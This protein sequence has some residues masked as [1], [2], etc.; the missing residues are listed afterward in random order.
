VGQQVKE[1]DLPLWD[2]LRAQKK[3]LAAMKTTDLLFIYKA[4]HSEPGRL[5]V[6][7][8]GPPTFPDGETYIPVEYFET[9]ERFEPWMGF[10]TLFNNEMEVLAWVS[11]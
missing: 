10:L 8:D 2:R 1:L 6:R 11:K 5:V 4:R 3:R 9:G 7:L